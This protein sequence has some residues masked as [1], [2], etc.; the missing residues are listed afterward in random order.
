MAA[1]SSLA[2]LGAARSALEAQIVTLGKEQERVRQNLQAIPGLKG[3][4]IASE[5]NKKTASTLLQRYLK[6]LADVES[7]LEA[8]RQEHNQLLEREAKARQELEKLVEGLV[9]E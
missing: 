9:V 5:E 3:N 4:E 8:Q 7:E 1:R 6:K 2:E